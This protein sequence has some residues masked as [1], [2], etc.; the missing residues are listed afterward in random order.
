M[1]LRFCVRGCNLYQ[2]FEIALLLQTD[3]TTGR[4]VPFSSPL[5]SSWDSRYTV[6]F[7][8]A[9]ESW[10][11]SIFSCQVSRSPTLPCF[12]L[13]FSCSVAGVY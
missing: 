2:P 8:I 5:A 7:R 12:Q 6:Y 1:F 10:V 3:L 4:G 13:S 11:I 9:T